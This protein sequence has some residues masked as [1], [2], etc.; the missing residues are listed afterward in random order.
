[1]SDLYLACCCAEDVL[2]AMVAGAAVEQVCCWLLELVS[3]SM[4]VSCACASSGGKIVF[5]LRDTAAEKESGSSSVPGEL[6]SA[7]SRATGEI[8]CSAAAEPVADGERW[9]AGLR[10]S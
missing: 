10:N 7:G 6:V 4:M 1:M 9:E 3:C 2:L 5:T 8:S